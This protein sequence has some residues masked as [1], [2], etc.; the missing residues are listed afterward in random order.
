MA[1]ELKSGEKTLADMA[2]VTFASPQAK[3]EFLRK[4]AATKTKDDVADLM[5][6]NADPGRIN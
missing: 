3:D 2:V 5:V 6:G 4:L 1:K